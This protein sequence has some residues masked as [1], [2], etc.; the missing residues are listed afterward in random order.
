MR[1]RGHQM[2]PIGTPW[3][4]ARL[5]RE[6][7][8]WDGILNGDQDPSVDSGRVRALRHVSFWA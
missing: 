7:V 8:G 5:K 1:L 6:R 4:V 3:S 2:G